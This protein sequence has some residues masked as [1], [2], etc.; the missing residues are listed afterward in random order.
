MTTVLCCLAMT[1][2]PASSKTHAQRLPFVRTD[3]I[4]IERF[5]QLNLIGTQRVELNNGRDGSGGN[6]FRLGPFYADE[7]SDFLVETIGGECPQEAGTDGTGRA[8]TTVVC[9]TVAY[10]SISRRFRR[11]PTQLLAPFVYAGVGHETSTAFDVYTGT[12]TYPET[13]TFVDAERAPLTHDL[14]GRTLVFV[15]ENSTVFRPRPYFRVPGLFGVL[16]PLA[17]KSR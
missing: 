14:A 8:I 10:V 16:M 2:P 7:S 1:L 5:E 11:P 9:S 6:N 13:W 12:L 3:T 17:S 15:E 4:V